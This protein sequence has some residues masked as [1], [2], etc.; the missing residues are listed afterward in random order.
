M[1]RRR[2][3]YGE[4]FQPPSRHKDS[5]R[6]AESA[7]RASSR[8]ADASGAPDRRTGNSG[9][10]AARQSGRR[11]GNN[12]AATRR[13]P[14]PVA[15]RAYALS[16]NCYKP[17][18][19]RRASNCGKPA[20]RIFFWADAI[21]YS[22]AAQSYQIRVGI[23]DGI[24]GPAIAVARLS[25]EPGLMS[26]SRHFRGAICSSLDSGSVPTSRLTPLRWHRNAPC[27]CVCPKKETL[28]S[29]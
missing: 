22:V 13:I 29:R 4:K 25:T 6:A 24:A 10:L 2:I 15:H 1:E 26:S 3:G 11:T 14:S 21:S 28:Q 19:N 23:I 5:S 18:S 27:K 8:I 16:F 9:G 7:D 17:A 20:S 12:L